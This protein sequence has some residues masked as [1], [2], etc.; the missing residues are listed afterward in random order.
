M[1]FLGELKR[2]NV[3]RVG[4]V[5]AVVGWLLVQVS[6]SLE[7]AVGLPEWFD[8]L[9]V[10]LLA[11]GFPIALIFAWAF[12]LT[13]DGIKRTADVAEGES[14]TANTG[15]KLDA[16]LV[17]ALLIFAA[18]MVVPKLLQP[19]AGSSLIGSPAVGAPSIAVLPF[20]DLS[21][22]GDQ[23]YF[24]DGISEELL[25]VLAKVDGMKV[26]GRTSSFA[27]KGRNE[28]LREIG[29]VLDVAHILEGSVRSQGDKV[30][31]T[32]QLIQ[33]SD[34]FHLWSETYD[35]DLTDI[36]A[37][38]DDIASQ[39]LVAMK[40][41]LGVEAA[42]TLA[43]VQRADVAAYG[44]FL[45][46]RDL[47]FTRKPENME[48]A[49]ELLNTA[50]E[51][52]PN[53]APAYASRAKAYALL[54][55]RPGSYGVLPADIAIRGAERDVEQ[56]LLLDPNLADAYAVQGLL[57][58]DSGRSDF[59]ISSLRRAIELNPNSLDA[60]NWLALAL[61]NDG[62]LRDVTAQLRSLVDI[63]PLYKPGVSN[64]FSYSVTIG[65]YDAARRIAERYINAVDDETE[66]RLMRVQILYDL[67]N[68]HADAIK[69]R[70]TVPED[71]A[72]SLTNSSLRSAY[73][74]LGVI[75]EYQGE[76]EVLPLWRPWNFIRRK[77]YE[78]GLQM[79][80]QA[81]EDEPEYYGAH[82]VYIDV[83]SFLYQDKE[84]VR[85]F[86][87]QY[88]SSL[89]RYAALL[90]PGVNS[91]PPPYIRLALA[92]RATGN[93]AMFDE[94]WRRCRFQLDIFSAGGDVSFDHD[95][96]EAAYW[97]TLGNKDKAL[98]FLESAF[99]KRNP[100]DFGEFLG[101]EFEGLR[102]DKRFLALRQKNLDRIN[103]ERAILGFK[104]LSVFFYDD[105]HAS[106]DAYVDGS[107]R[108]LPRESVQP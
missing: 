71:A 2:R 65:E 105:F 10:S 107:V 80:R 6:A 73:Y 98:T 12:E 102:S 97:A 38:Q 106:L 37:V 96:E 47:I 77:D 43:P 79:A 100:L 42:P 82:A 44:L 72:N 89:E 13:A 70:E 76:A 67:E 33:V 63:D 57:N 99:A 1:S 26:A 104:P 30:R 88:G 51:I 64:A 29:R 8:G 19:G 9:V 15:S 68:R 83:L 7:E 18:A 28:D 24:A 58:S 93:D 81:V 27:F 61:A 56:A 103:E 92:M 69:L 40:T 53:Y 60:R 86:E 21:P 36:F 54:S 62:R 22:A 45:E 87:S 46:A 23:E 14:I 50:I 49:M 5:Y 4:G 84:L 55:D 39:I 52:D 32:A 16:V 66:K 34:G 11:I 94:A 75:D 25:N 20:A 91:E 90:R 3:I 35:G 108:D 59:A 31:V 78:A 101:R 17:I 85:Y 41:Q 48:R 74:S 95:R